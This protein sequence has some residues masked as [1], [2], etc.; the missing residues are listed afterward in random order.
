MHRLRYPFFVRTHRA[1]SSCDIQPHPRFAAVMVLIFVH[2]S[3]L[4]SDLL[5]HPILSSLL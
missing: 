2:V 1:P 4:A 3:F 5:P